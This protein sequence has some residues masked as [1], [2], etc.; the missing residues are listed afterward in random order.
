MPLFPDNIAADLIRYGVVRVPRYRKPKGVDTVQLYLVEAEVND[1]P[2]KKIG[3]TNL[4]DPLTR[5]RKAY[6]SLI[7][8][9][10]VPVNTA[11]A[12]E[13]VALGLCD[14]RHRPSNHL[15]SLKLIY[16]WAGACEAIFTDQ[17]ITPTFDEAIELCA[18][19]SYEE[20][21]AELEEL[22]YLLSAVAR[23]YGDP[24][25]LKP[26]IKT[27]RKLLGLEEVEARKQWRIA[28]GWAV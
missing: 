6:K 8:S 7:K 26:R 15:Q 22:W 24:K 13:A 1:V 27:M 2:F 14:G 18:G 20:L 23:H 17:D 10:S 25:R 11:G 28:N 16:G 3:L 5:D 21:K 12:I 19:H 9:V 4:T